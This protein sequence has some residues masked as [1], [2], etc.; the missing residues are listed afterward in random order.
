ML[1][2]CGAQLRNAPASH[3][4]AQPYPEV[5]PEIRSTAAGRRR[6]ELF[7]EEHNV[8]PGW[9]TVGQK[10]AGSNF[11]AGT[12]AAHFLQPD[13]APYVQSNGAPRPGAPHLLGTTPEI[14]ELRPKSPP[15]R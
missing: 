14:E 15:P 9:V 6:L 10:L 7:G 5:L 2:F 8:R 12:Y 4:A 3:T 11:S 1:W 13:G